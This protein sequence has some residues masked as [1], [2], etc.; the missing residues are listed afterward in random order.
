MTV[1]FSKQLLN[2]MGQPDEIKK[3]KLSIAYQSP[4]PWSSLIEENLTPHSPLLG[5]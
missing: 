1:R 4:D 3:L 2:L 5:T